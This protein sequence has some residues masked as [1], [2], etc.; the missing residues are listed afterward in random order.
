MQPR[1]VF[2]KTTFLT[3][4]SADDIIGNG[5]HIDERIITMSARQKYRTKQR[6]ILLD[7]F[8]HMSGTHIT[9]S[10]V[11]TYF[12]EQGAPIGKSTVYRQLESLVDE[13]II[14]KYIIGVGSPA[15]FEYAGKAGDG[16]CIGTV[17]HCKCEKCGRLIHL[18]CDEIRRLKEHL[19]DEYRFRMDPA[20][21]VFYGLCE[22]CIKRDY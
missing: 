22:D 10:D 15:C 1:P 21:T 20:R 5:S 8:E 16:R 7:Y 14:N 3:A 13:G 18:S 9:A 4:Y 6:E 11:C 17:F 12:K 2:L 19:Y